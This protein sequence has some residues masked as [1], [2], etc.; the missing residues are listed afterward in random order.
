MI[1]LDWRSF[2]LFSF[3]W[4]KDFLSRDVAF[5]N[6]EWAIKNRK[7]LSFAPVVYLWVLLIEQAK[8][9]IW[10][11]IKGTTQNVL[12]LKLLWVTP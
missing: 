2:R 8:K 1:W 11:P 4:F 7:D 6:L 10:K 3:V 9:G 5:A 12:D